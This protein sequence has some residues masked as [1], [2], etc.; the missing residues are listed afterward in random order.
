MDGLIPKEALS[1][2]LHDEQT[3]QRVKEAGGAS[4]GPVLPVVPK[5]V[6]EDAL[7]DKKAHALAEI[8]ELQKDHDGDGVPDEH[9]HYSEPPVY[10]DYHNALLPRILGTI[11]VT[12]WMTCYYPQIYLNYSRKSC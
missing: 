10:A 9:D 2:S 3:K 6:M 8:S 11:Y 4:G 7:N 5:Q 1:S 12:C